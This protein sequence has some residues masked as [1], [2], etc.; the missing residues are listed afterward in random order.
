MYDQVDGIFRA[1]QY[2]EAHLESE[3]TVS[4]IADEVGY[5]LFHFMRTFN[6]M[7]HH[8]PFDYLTRRRLC[9]AA[10]KL[11]STD[12]RIIDIALDYGFNNQESFSRAFKRM[13]HTQPSQ[14]REYGMENAHLLM[15]PKTIMDLRFI[16]GHRFEIPIIVNLEE[17]RYFGLMTALEKKNGLHNS[18]PE[19]L[20]EDLIDICDKPAQVTEIITSIHQNF[21][22]SY[23]FLGVDEQRI[24]KPGV[25]PVSV[26]IPAGKYARIATLE[27][28]SRLALTYLYH[29]WI[30]RNGLNPQ[31][32]MEF[33]ILD[34][35][36]KEQKRKTIYVPVT[37]FDG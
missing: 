18:Q 4:Q 23:L 36:G 8:T 26:L 21:T 30:P 37:C 7:V 11:I 17:T 22:K 3:V 9:E 1:I 20:Y 33:S 10:K 13:F 32:Q 25:L 31:G 16:N 35:G 19:S 2:M 28:D 15:P 27:K 14:W 34:L 6:R 12:R 24:F 29:T 5:S